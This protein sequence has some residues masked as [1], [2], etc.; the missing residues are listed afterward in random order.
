MLS[1][2]VAL[3]ALCGPPLLLGQPDS[4]M[5]RFSARSASACAHCLFLGRDIASS[6]TCVR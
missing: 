4:V 5:A 1:P 3:L 2:L 6:V